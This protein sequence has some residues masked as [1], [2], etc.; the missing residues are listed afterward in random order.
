MMMKLQV[1]YGFV[2]YAVVL[3]LPGD[4]STFCSVAGD[5]AAG[6]SFLTLVFDHCICCNEQASAHATCSRCRCQVDSKMERSPIYLL[7]LKT[8][9]ELEAK[10]VQMVLTLGGLQV[11]FSF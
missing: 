5:K 1:L 2:S 3:Q 4:I 8:M 9:Q 11:F 6:A 10:Y 7:C